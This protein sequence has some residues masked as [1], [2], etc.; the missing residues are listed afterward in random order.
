[1]TK[2]KKNNDSDAEES[3]PIDSNEAHSKFERS[4]QSQTSKLSKKIVKNQDLA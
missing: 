4:K 2:H 3:S 1:M